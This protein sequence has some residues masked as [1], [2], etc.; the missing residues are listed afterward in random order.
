MMVQ[1]YDIN[2][3][4]IH[5]FPPLEVWNNWTERMSYDGEEVRL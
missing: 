5:S 2:T 1:K 3:K 4:L